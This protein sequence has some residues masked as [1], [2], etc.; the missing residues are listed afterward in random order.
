L[1]SVHSFAS[2]IDLSREHFRHQWSGGR[3]E[4]SMVIKKGSREIAN[5]RSARSFGFA[6]LARVLVDTKKKASAASCNR[7][8]EKTPKKPCML[9]AEPAGNVAKQEENNSSRPSPRV[10]PLQSF[11]FFRTENHTTDQD[12]TQSR[13]PQQT[14]T[15]SRSCTIQAD[16]R[17]CFHI[18]SAKG[19]TRHQR[20]W[21]LVQQQRNASL[22]CSAS[23]RLARRIEAFQKQCLRKVEKTLNQIGLMV[24]I[25]N[26]QNI[27]SNQKT[28]RL[29][30]IL[31]SLQPRPPRFKPGQFVLVCHIPAAMVNTTTGSRSHCPTT[32]TISNY[33]PNLVNRH[34]YPR[35]GGGSSSQTS[36]DDEQQQKGPYLFVLAEIRQVHHCG[37]GLLGGVQY[38]IVRVDTPGEESWMEEVFME[39]ILSAHGRL[40]AF[41]RTWPTTRTANSHDDNE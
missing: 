24:A 21:R 12:K 8:L 37:D 40:A 6:S 27:I 41:S 23:K 14:S 22:L 2:L 28:A 29:D 39:P 15:G 38:T 17:R 10:P 13:Q 5:H 11:A 18:P 30:R 7:G 1:L 4:Q 20:P 3:E 36:L 34:G 26:H 33:T 19:N 25:H 9:S 16:L 32:S 35:D 31:H